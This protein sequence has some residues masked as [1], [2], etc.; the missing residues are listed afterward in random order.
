MTIK[1]CLKS[2]RL[3]TL[4]L[5]LA[6]IIAGISL[7]STVAPLKLA[8]VVTLVLTTVF[9]QI[10]SNLSN[11][12]GDTLHGTDTEERAGMHYSLQDGE[13]TIP[14]M[15]KLI[16]VIVVLCCV[17]GLAMIFF[18]FGNLL[19]LQPAALVLLGAAAIWAAMHYTLGDNP[20]GYRGLGDIFVFIFFGLVATLGAA[21]V[22]SHEFSLSWLLP[23]A[24]FG[25]WSVGVLN[26]NN[27]RDMVT[28]A[29][30]RTTVAIKLGARNARIYHSLLLVFGWIFLLAYT[31]LASGGAA[32]Y[33][34]V[35]AIPLSAMHLKAV[36][37]KSGKALDPMLPMLVMTTFAVALLFTIG[38]CIG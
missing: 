18:S 30:T 28:D 27:I 25:F 21:Y 3:R 35:L 33:M 1:S 15:K 13:M 12:L 38:N 17:S 10:L 11:E 19:A 9:L 26:V 22:C 6:G 2:M 36:W 4:P 37:T 34:Y 7:A 23:A 16:A 24:A 8:T 32:S 20:Y 31:I 14:Q 5:S 29:A